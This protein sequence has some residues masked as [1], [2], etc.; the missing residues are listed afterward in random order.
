[1]AEQKN[2][3]AYYEYA[4]EDKYVAGMVLLGTEVKSIRGGKVSFNDSFC[5]FNKGE[6]YVKSL[7]IAQYSHGTSSNHDPLRE[8]KLLLNKREIRKIENKIREKGYTIIPL[9]LF[10]SD[11]GLAKLE[12]GV[13]RGKKLYDK[14]ESIKSRDADRELKRQFKQ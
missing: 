3:S 13:G 7:H 12:I 10:I 1:M 2:R 11:K 14:R 8:R 5:Y 6:L 4:I 9:R